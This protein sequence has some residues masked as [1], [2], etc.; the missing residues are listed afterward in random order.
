MRG[1][2]DALGI[3]PSGVCFGR[4]QHLGG[5]VLHNLR[6]D[7][8]GLQPGGTHFFCEP[9]AESLLQSPYQ[10]FTDD[11]VLIILNPVGHMSAT[12]TLQGR[13]E[14]FDFW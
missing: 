2:L 14:L 12:Q 5:G 9:G 7:G 10:N 4:V 11:I 1:G 8:V 13:D 3:V 6:D